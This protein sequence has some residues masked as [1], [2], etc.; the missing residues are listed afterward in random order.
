M[1]LKTLKGFSYFFIGRTFQKLKKWKYAIYSYKKAIKLDN[2]NALWHFRL[3]NAHQQVDKWN[4]A[5]NSYK[6]AVELDNSKGLWY[7]RL[8]NAHQQVDKWNDA[9]NSYKKAVELD[10]SKELWREALLFA[11]KISKGV[12][13]LVN[14][15][16]KKNIGGWVLIKENNND[17][18]I[19]VNGCVIT[20][21]TP[22]RKVI[23]DSQNK[24][25]GYF[26]RSIKGIWKYLGPDDYLEIEYCG[27]TL[28]IARNFGFRLNASVIRCNYESNFSELIKK[29]NEGYVF[30]KY[31]S[32]KL[33]IKK[34]E[35]W[36][37]L[38]F[39][40]FNKLKE[41]LKKEFNL[42]LL[43]SYGTL[44]G[45]VREGDFISHDN[46][47]DTCYISEKNTPEELK[48]EFK[49]ICEFLINN[50]YKLRVKKTHAW[51]Y[52]Q[53]KETFDFKLDLYFSYFNE[54]DEYRVN[55]GH[56]G[57]PVKKSNDFFNYTEVKLSNYPI[58]IPSNHRDILKQIYGETWETPDP[59]F[60]HQEDTRKRDKNYHLSYVEQ[61]DFYW[62]QFYKY[63]S[64]SKCSSFS[65]YI[66]NNIPQKSK[67]IEL[68]CGCGE[69]ALY[70]AQN[71]HFI[72][73][74]EKVSDTFPKGKFNNIYFSNLDVSN[75]LDLKNFLKKA[76]S[77]DS[78]KFTGKFI[79]YI[80]FLINFLPEEIE[81]EVFRILS[82]V[83]PTGSI[84]AIEFISEKHIIQ[85]KILKRLFRKINQKK[86]IKK[87]Q[88]FQYSIDQ[89]IET[90]G[91]SVNQEDKKFLGNDP[92]L[93]RIIAQKMNK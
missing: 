31:G 21:T 77:I 47:F 20:K 51:I 43:P 8:G 1:K 18:I 39:E 4:D 92:F 93:G 6:N 59:G 53:G 32:L 55:Y 46:D 12:P 23:I 38:I 2:S 27:E 89:S 74:C 63:K 67:I 15:F 62:K 29:I 37:V 10:N 50:G 17:V 76:M 73:A 90:K 70:F 68:G 87:L 28:Q 83:I 75:S 65:I 56:H 85:R 80:R 71:G 69:D 30:N 9:F 14:R 82:Q 78:I 60:K 61:I 49:K 25:I 64:I 24:K 42:V 79:V 19:K 91:L 72:H 84:L 13:G 54:D 34:N 22:E 41:D 5:I 58:S 33:S 11:S 66:N 16:D 3:G 26:L 44:L 35:L 86:L 7:F 57:P 88:S 45:A 36:Q 40:L 81:T 48:N 52:A